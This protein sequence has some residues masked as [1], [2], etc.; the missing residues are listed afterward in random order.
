[1]Y[2]DDF[3][4]LE[5]AFDQY[6]LCFMEKATEDLLHLPTRDFTR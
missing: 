1:M 5:I 4:I 3:P 2:F 6:I